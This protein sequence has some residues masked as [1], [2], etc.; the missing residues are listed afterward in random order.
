MTK[1][2]KRFKCRSEAQKRAIRC[3]YA[4]KRNSNNNSNRTNNVS[5]LSNKIENNGFP[6]KF[7]FWA[8]LKVFKNRTTLV[9]DEKVVAN[10]SSNKQEEFYVHREATHTKGRGEKIFPNPD[11]TDPLPMYLKSPRLLPK[12]LFVPH[13]GNLDMP[14]YLVELYKGNNKKGSSNNDN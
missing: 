3:N 14:D 10:D 12:K 8:R 5:I 9:V 1:K 6:Q 7:P 13:N 11:K 2:K 4:K